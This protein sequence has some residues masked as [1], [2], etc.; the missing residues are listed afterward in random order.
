MML[1]IT[2]QEREFL[3]DLLES[4]HTSLLD[5]LHHTDTHEYKDMLKQKMEVLEGLRA[6][7]GAMP[8]ADAIG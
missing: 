5:E 1:D 8:S 4:K 7:V 6:K 3:A 2:D